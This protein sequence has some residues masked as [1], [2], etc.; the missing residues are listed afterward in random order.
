MADDADK[1]RRIEERAHRLWEEEG[2][3][4]GRADAHWE[5]ARAIIALEDGHKAT[6]KPVEIESAEPIEALVNQGE[7]PTTTDQ[8]EQVIPHRGSGER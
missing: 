5:Q 7:F 6:L 8:G 3:P 2:R 4:E 1:K